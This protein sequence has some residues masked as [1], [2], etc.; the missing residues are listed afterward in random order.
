MVTSPSARSGG[1]PDRRE[2]L[3]GLGT[4]PG[5]AA[6]PAHVIRGPADAIDVPGGAVLV[7]RVINPYLAPLFF[8]I[9]GV[10]VEEGGL[11]QH[12]TTLAR[13]FGVPAVVQIPGATD[14]LRTGERLEVNGTTG[15]VRREGAG[16]VPPAT[17]PPGG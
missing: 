17:G 4:S 13:E 2:V 6:G 7:A 9:V 14:I 1:G 11:L 10:V 15:E 3:V 16:Q 8:R 5:I 12:A